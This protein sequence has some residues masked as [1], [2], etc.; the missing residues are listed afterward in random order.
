MVW[1]S[2]GLGLGISNRREL[3]DQVMRAPGAAQRAS[4][5]SGGRTGPGVLHLGPASG[6]RAAPT[7]QGDYDTVSWC[8]GWRRGDGGGRSHGRHAARVAPAAQPG[9]CSTVEHDDARRVKLPKRGVGGRHLR[10][11]PTG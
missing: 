8:Q 10:P 11:D 6:C 3:H 4:A 5:F 7:T 1:R 9:S 2:S